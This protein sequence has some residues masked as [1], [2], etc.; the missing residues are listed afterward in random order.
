MTVHGRPTP[1]LR[2]NKTFNPLSTTSVAVSSG[3][4]RHLPPSSL[5]FLVPPYWSADVHV[6][7][8]FD[9]ECLSLLLLLLPIATVR[10]DALTAAPRIREDDGAD[11]DDTDVRSAAVAAKHRYV[12][13]L[14]RV[15]VRIRHARAGAPPPPDDKDDEDESEA[16]AIL[17]LSLPPSVGNPRESLTFARP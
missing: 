10:A 5:L 1:T 3:T 12:D 9:A 6:D 16:V 2:S 14:E 13:E 7:G 17:S 15:E 11:V 4:A 8:D